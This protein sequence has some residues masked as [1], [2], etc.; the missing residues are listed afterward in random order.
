MKFYIESFERERAW[1]ITV[2]L[3]NNKTYARNELS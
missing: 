2:F 1:F 3:T